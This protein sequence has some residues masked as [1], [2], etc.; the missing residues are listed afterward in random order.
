MNKTFANQFK[1]VNPEI[2]L[3][4]IQRRMFIVGTLSEDGSFSFSAK[5]ALHSTKAMAL[6]ESKRLADLKPGTAYIVVQFAGGS[7][8]PK[9]IN[10]YDL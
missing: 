9:V 8:V 6:A 10:G 3:D 2:Y 5:P 4:A 7:L 1:P